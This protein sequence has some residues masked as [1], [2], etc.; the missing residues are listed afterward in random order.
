MYFVHKG[1]I[2]VVFECVLV[3]ITQ[4]S[5]IGINCR[6]FPKIGPRLLGLVI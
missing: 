4:I 3:K 1:D 2:F 6:G 5:N